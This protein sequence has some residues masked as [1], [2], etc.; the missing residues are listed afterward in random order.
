MAHVVETVVAAALVGFFVW[1]WTIY[2]RTQS[3]GAS[4]RDIKDDIVEL[5]TQTVSLQARLRIQ[6]DNSLAI[7]LKMEAIPGMDRKID[8]LLRAQRIEPPRRAVER[9]E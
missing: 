7:N 6:E 4:L 8:E 2:N 5:K 1:I 3:H 9:A